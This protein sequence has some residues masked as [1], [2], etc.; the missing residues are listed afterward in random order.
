MDDVTIEDDIQFNQ[1]FS[2][3][4]SIERNWSHLCK[5]SFPLFSYL[6]LL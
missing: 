4:K 2:K 1:Q 6:N 3:E 5:S